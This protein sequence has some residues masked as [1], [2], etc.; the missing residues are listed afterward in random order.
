MQYLCIC[1][2][3]LL[4]SCNDRCI[5]VWEAN[6]SKYWICLKEK[7]N[8]E[9]ALFYG[10]FKISDRTIFYRAVCED[11]YI[12]D[13]ILS[14]KLNSYEFSRDTLFQELV[15]FEELPLLPLTLPKHIEGTFDT[16][17]NEYT[18]NIFTGISYSHSEK[19]HLV[20]TSIFSF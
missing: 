18:A 17:F 5:E 11:V 9:D 2:V 12:N 6:S 8:W 16:T 15:S 4:I 10:S 1:L 19:V 13:S 20:K 7:S 14:F 3:F